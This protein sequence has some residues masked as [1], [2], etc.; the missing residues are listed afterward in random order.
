MDTGAK[1]VA[2]PPSA[3]AKA[4]NGGPPPSPANGATTPTRERRTSASH[5]FFP[6]R[7]VSKRHRTVSAASVD[8]V[9]GTVGGNSTILTSPAGSTRSPTPKLPAPQRDPVQ[10]TNEWRIK[11]DADLRDAPKPRRKRPGV[12]FEG[13][14]SDHPHAQRNKPAY[15]TRPSRPSR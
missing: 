10:A 2:F 1:N 15:H 14:E 7:L 13:Y 12:T 9:D 11:E 8:A 6:F 5:Q 3:P 4:A